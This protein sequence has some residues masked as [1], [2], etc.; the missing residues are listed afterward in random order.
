MWKQALERLRCCVPGSDQRTRDRKGGSSLRGQRAEIKSLA[1]ALGR[2]REHGSPGVGC[3]RLAS[4]QQPG[5]TPPRAPRSPLARASRPHS[6]RPFCAALCSGFLWHLDLPP[7]SRTSGKSHL[8]L[9]L[10]VLRVPLILTPFAAQL[11]EV[12]HHRWSPT[13]A[14]QTSAQRLA[15]RPPFLNSLF[16]GLRGPRLLLVLIFGFLISTCL[17]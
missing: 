16:L 3:E 7:S 4:V 8:D 13:V 14:P 12:Q 6:P 5:R 1:L 17:L 11:E 2:K 10:L 9:L 15:F